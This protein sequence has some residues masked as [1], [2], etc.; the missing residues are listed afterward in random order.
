[1]AQTVATA[2][3]NRPGQLG[4]ATP[5]RSA[6][7]PHRVRRERNYEDQKEHGSPQV[8]LDDDPHAERRPSQKHGQAKCEPHT[9]RQARKPRHAVG[10]GKRQVQRESSN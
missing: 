2:T 9:H 5:T 6:N 10:I 7:Y 8:Q 4:Q 3:A 1:M